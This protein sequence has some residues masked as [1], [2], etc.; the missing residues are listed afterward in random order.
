MILF[1]LLDLLYRFYEFNN[2]M[3]R[4]T[5]VLIFL[6]LLTFGFNTYFYLWT[7]AGW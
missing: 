7:Y 3:L 4:N 6:L 5:Y 1:K 2:K